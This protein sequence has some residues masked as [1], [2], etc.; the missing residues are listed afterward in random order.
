MMNDRKIL[1][2]IVFVKSNWVVLP[3]KIS[4][5]IRLEWNPNWRTDVI[6]PERKESGPRVDNYVHGPGIAYAIIIKDYLTMS[7]P[8]IWC[9]DKYAFW[10][11]LV[12][13]INA[14]L[15]K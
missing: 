9:T 8:L 7:K 15:L 14:E 10:G 3:K 6:F 13:I 2:A 5:K 11:E 12:R 1:G 4:Y